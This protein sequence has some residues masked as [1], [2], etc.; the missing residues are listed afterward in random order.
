MDHSSVELL[1]LKITGGIVL[2]L[3]AMVYRNLRNR[4]D[5]SEA[6]IKNRIDKNEEEI[7]WI[8]TTLFKDYLCKDDINRLMDK[9]LAK[10]DI[11]ESKLDHKKDK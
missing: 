11:I 1:F 2:G 8:K 5:K 10:L 7:G 6:E 9:I 3:V 4:L